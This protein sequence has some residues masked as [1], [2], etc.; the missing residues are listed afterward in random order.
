MYF[1]VVTGG[2]TRPATESSI[3]RGVRSLARRRA[4]RDPRMEG[5]GNHTRA[6]AASGALREWLLSVAEISEQRVGRL[7]EILHED[8]EADTVLDVRVLASRVGGAFDA[9]LSE[10]AA[11][12]IRGALAGSSA[13]DTTAAVLT[14]RTP[15]AVDRARC[16]SPPAS[17]VRVVHFPLDNSSWDKSDWHRDLFAQRLNEMAARVE[18]RTPEPLALARRRLER[19]SSPVACGGFPLDESSWDK[20]EWHRELFAHRLNEVAARD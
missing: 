17:P 18:P 5:K 1:W 9:R 14:P 4:R 11:A 19:P 10:L 7:L 20:S 13:L 16:P 8:L 12:K 15:E 2:Y 3:A 6:P